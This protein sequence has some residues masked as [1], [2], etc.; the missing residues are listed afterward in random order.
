MSQQLISLSPDL[1]RLRKDGYEVSIE[2]GHLVVHGIPYLDAQRQVKR[3]TLV[4]TL[5]LSGNQTNRPDTHVVLFAG[6]YPCDQHGKPIE[7]IR[8]GSTRQ[9]IGA[10]L[11]VDHSFSS[12][13]T[14]GYPDYYAKMTTYAAILSSPA[15]ALD[16][17]ATPRTY[18]V[19][20]AP[21]DSPFVYF[22]NASG[23]AGISHITRK[24]MLNSVAIIGLGGTGS[25]VLDLVAKT[26]VARIDLFDADVFE[27][28]NAFRAPGAPSLDELR[29]RPR[30]VDYLAGIYSKM[31]KGV[32]PHS[33]PITAA[34]VDVLQDQAM[35]FLCID[36][37][38]IKL[39]IIRALEAFQ[40][41]FIDVGMGIDMVDNALIGTLRTTTS[42]PHFR[43]HVHD[44]ARIPM[45]DAGMD[46][47]YA[48]NIQVADLNAL[49]A[50]LAVIRWK[51]LCGF[52]RDTE[53]E[54]FS[55]FTLDANHLLNEDAA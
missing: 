42:T 43:T 35:V 51:K 47:L 24:L 34:N 17:S 29:Q 14:A 6:D 52:Y 4:S 37:S 19:I 53:G 9:A 50:C 18:R 21:D 15:A 48:Q 10:G 5:A 12:K 3:G 13:P 38:E 49:N 41:P 36:K 54:H 33:E 28:H 8:L 55:L 26:P 11:S 40:V 25:Y 23:R 45:T 32:V 44:R 2:H 20:E 31:H 39:P 30:K 7:K 22:D 16:P 1:T 27:Q 46:D